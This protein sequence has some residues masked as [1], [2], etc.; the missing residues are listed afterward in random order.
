MISE[1]EKAFHVPSPSP[2]AVSTMT[3]SPS[4]AATPYTLTVLPKYLDS[5]D[6]LR[7]GRTQYLPEP[8]PG[9]R[10]APTH[11]RQETKQPLLVDFSRSVE[12]KRQHQTVYQVNNVFCDQKGC[13][14]VSRNQMEELKAGLIQVQNDRCDAVMTWGRG[15]CQ[16]PDVYGSLNDII[17]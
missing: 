17:P 12:L 7:F 13:I 10:L 11:G 1:L 16:R 3:A 15:F 8:T 14:C 9:G 6:A 5:C 2:S 4:N